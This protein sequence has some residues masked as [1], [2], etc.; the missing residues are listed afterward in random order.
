MSWRLISRARDQPKGP[1]ETS[2][3]QLSLG[4]L[5]LEHGKAE[6]CALFVDPGVSGSSPYY[7]AYLIALATSIA[8][9][10]TL[11]LVTAALAFATMI[12][13]ALAWRE[14]IEQTRRAAATMSKAPHSSARKAA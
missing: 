3:R 12:E 14:P 2:P 5:F 7:A 8:S 13:V 6:L 1:A 4:Q 10:P 9:Y 11:L